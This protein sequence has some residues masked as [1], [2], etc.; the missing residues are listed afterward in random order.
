MTAKELY[1]K[2]QSDLEELQSSCTHE[3]LSD[4]MQQEWAP[5]HFTGGQVKV[6]VRCEKIIEKEFSFTLPT[7]EWKDGES[8]K[9][10][11][12]HRPEDDNEPDDV[13]II[14]KK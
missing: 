9:M 13:E 4:W 6:C 2:Y 12:I 10:T 14:T 7:S 11:L 5:G 1:S 8:Q 3:L